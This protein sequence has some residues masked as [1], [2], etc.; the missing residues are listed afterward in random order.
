[1]ADYIKA[2][3]SEAGDEEEASS[4]AAWGEGDLSRWLLVMDG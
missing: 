3:E 2:Q 4:A 1:V